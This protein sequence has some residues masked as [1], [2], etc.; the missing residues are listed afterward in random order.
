[1]CIERFKNLFKKPNSEDL[2]VCSVCG[3]TVNMRKEVIYADEKRVVTCWTCHP[4]YQNE[5]RSG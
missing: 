4:N 2:V 3:R 5:K 1:M